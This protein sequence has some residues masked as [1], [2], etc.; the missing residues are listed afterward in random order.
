[1][2][3]FKAYVERLDGSTI[4]F[5]LSDLLIRIISL[6][7]FPLIYLFLSIFN[8]FYPIKIGFL[9][10]VRLGHLI[11][12]TDLYLRRRYLGEEDKGLHI[13][14][15]YRPANHQV[16]TLFSRVISLVESEFLT[17][18]FAPIS[19][20]NTKFLL[21]MPFIGN[22]YRERVLAPSQVNFT[23]NEIIVGKQKLKEMGIGDN[24][25]YACI[26]ARDNAFTLSLPGGKNYI[27][28][29]NY[30]NADIDTYNL[31]AMEVIKRGGFVIRMGSIVEKEFCLKHPKI[32]DYP[33]TYRDD[34]SDVFISAYAKFFISTANGS[35]DLAQLFDVPVLLV[36][37]VPIGFSPLSKNSIYIPKRIF[38]SSG[39][40]VKFY[41]QLL[42]FQ[43]LPLD[44]VTNP[45]K[46]LEEK[47]WQVK[48]NT[49]EE[50]RD[51]TIEMFG[52]IE[53]GFKQ[54]SQ[55]SATLARYYG[56]FEEANMYSI[57]KSPCAQF[58]LE[59]LDLTKKIN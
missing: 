8:Y 10:R 41:E 16:C 12:N 58:F 40:Q 57:S 51:A 39:Q 36:N 59:T 13:F 34:F 35:V 3:I 25:W 32:I 50:I 56:L 1:M 48:D 6:L 11:S 2:K 26:H 28:S 9:Y 22:E 52:Q 27:E 38:N 4:Y 54:S 24:D 21:K 30:R 45:L 55:Y 7:C 5:I 37:V 14:F 20:F 29:G 43:K 23:P 53:C 44:A 33:F 18:L 42:F 47:G 46:Y 17:K 49:R 19:I 31:A 15:T